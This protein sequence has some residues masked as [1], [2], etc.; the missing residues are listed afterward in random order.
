MKSRRYKTQKFIEQAKNNKKDNAAATTV[1]AITPTVQK[2]QCEDTAANID[3]S[4]HC[5]LGQVYGG[6][7]YGHVT[8]SQTTALTKQDVLFHV[9]LYNAQQIHRQQPRLAEAASPQQEHQDQQ[10]DQQ[11][12]QQQQYIDLET[13]TVKDLKLP[14]PFTIT[15]EQIHEATKTKKFMVRQENRL[16]KFTYLAYL[17]LM[18]M[19][20]FDTQPENEEVRN[21]LHDLQENCFVGICDPVETFKRQKV[22]LQ[23]VDVLRKFYYSNAALNEHRH[24][25]IATSRLYTQLATKERQKPA[26]CHNLLS[27]GI[28]G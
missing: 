11:L 18:F 12:Q 22:R 25:E 3:L 7:D 6:T 9:S 16:K 23:H 20:N 24:R 21:A 4:N 27:G 17:A 28:A 26:S 5:P 2:P 13:L 15:H 8:M 10:Q 1:P 14:K 19:N